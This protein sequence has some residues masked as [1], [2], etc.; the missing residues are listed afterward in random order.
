MINSIAHS[1]RFVLGDAVD[2]SPVGEDT[3]GMDSLDNA[4]R[5]DVMIPLG[6]HT[7]HGDSF[8]PR[9]LC[10]DSVIATILEASHKFFD[11]IA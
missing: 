9:I 7:E 10:N 3:A 2:A 11:E 1:L 8:P 6:R 4:A 5:A